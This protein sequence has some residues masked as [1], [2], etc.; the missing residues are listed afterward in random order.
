MNKIKSLSE[1]RQIRQRLEEEM[2]I[3]EKSNNPDEMVQIRVAMATCGIAAGARTVMN[4]LIDKIEK[5][6]IPAIVTQGGCMGYCYA[7][8]TI[9]V[10][11]PGEKPVVFGKVDVARAVEILD[12]YVKNGELVDDVISVDYQTIE[13]KL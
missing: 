8:P 13:E 10:R 12:R 2:N 6:K 3:R 5:E 4:T 7:E 9:E 11:K 1:L